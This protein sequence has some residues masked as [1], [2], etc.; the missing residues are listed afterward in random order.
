M[1]II[2]WIAKNVTL[3]TLLVT[4]VLM[5]ITL[6]YTLIT[7]R[8]LRLSSQPTIRI[9]PKGISIHPDISD[10]AKIGGKKDDLK[11]DRY[12]IT[13]DFELANIGAHPAQNIY[14]DAEAH[15]KERKPLG[16]NLLPVHLP[17]FL[18]FLSPDKD[19]NSENFKIWAR[20]DNYVAREL[21]RDFFQGRT[22]LEGLAFLPSK[23]EIND[24]S[25]W[26]SPKLV[27]RCLYSDIQGQNYI[28]ELQ[29]FFHI[30]K[31]NEKNKLDIYL[32]N[33]QE[34]EFIGIRKVKKRYRD[35]YINSRRNLRY[36]SFSG[37]KYSKND[38]LLLSKASKTVK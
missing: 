23:K 8:M 28:S 6:S 24:R 22:N 33:M 14:F 2:E 3:L 13:A 11:N 17:E 12:C 21:I 10:A 29:L 27:I 15:F 26:P 19:S 37:E 4:T 5:I 36:M 7:R 9:K 31:D 1:Y 18:S 16:K 25:L 34:L 20:F 30:W 38:L 32:L 35:H